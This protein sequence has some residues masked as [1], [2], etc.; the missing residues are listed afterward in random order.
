MGLVLPCQ[1]RSHLH[2]HLHLLARRVRRLLRPTAEILLL[3]TDSIWAM[4]M[5]PFGNSIGLHANAVICCNAL[6]YRMVC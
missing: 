2:L 1:P 3:N 6:F 4:C 5:Q